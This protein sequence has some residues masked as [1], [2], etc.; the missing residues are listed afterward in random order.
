M[1][2]LELSRA[3]RAGQRVYGTLITSPSPH[4]PQHL[5]GIGLDY[6]FIDTEHIPISD[7]DLAWMCQTCRALN[8]APIVRIPAPDPYRACKVLDGGACGI[9]APYVETLAEVQALRGAVKLRPLKGK[10]L[11]DALEGTA[12][13]VEPLAS[14]LRERSEGRLLFINIESVPAV[15]NLDQIL[16]VPGIDAVQIGPHD[17][18]VSMGIPEQY[19]HPEFDKMVRVIIKK[20]RAHNIGVGIH[21]WNSL[22]QEIEWAKCGATLF[23]HS[24]DVLLFTKALEK[25]LKEARAALGDKL[26]QGGHRVEMI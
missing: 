10:K 2:G 26:E 8:L 1:N 9:I 7:H 5:T 4:L 14:Y 12:E 18:S 21:F 6:V 25:D 19:D 13:P 11:A 3:L 15:E 20:A 22:E 17:L 16:A 23:L 24:A